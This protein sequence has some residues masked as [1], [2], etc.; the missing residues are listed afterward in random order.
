MQKS[1]ACLTGGNT[2]LFDADTKLG[3]S[4]VQGEYGTTFCKPRRNKQFS[5]RINFDPAN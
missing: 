2:Q 5:F 3:V 4:M 1:I